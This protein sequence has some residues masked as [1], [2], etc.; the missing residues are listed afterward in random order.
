[1]NE[2]DADTK[3]QAY[4]GTAFAEKPRRKAEFLSDPA[5]NATC[6]NVELIS[7]LVKKAIRKHN[8]DWKKS[9]EYRR[10]QE[11][12]RIAGAAAA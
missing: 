1:M 5:N 3:L 8:D 9:D 7:S 10:I 2:F 11:N 12:N 6:E 4:S